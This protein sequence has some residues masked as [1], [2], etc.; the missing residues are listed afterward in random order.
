M[1]GEELFRAGFVEDAFNSKY[2]IDRSDRIK[3]GRKVMLSV[4]SIRMELK[5]VWTVGRGVYAF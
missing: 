5:S 2:N 1:F 3:S 4:Y